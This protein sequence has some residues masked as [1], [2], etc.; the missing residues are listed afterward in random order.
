MMK[1]KNGFIKNLHYLCLI[2]VI[3]LGLM[4]II[5]T[6]G[7]GGSSTT[8]TIN[9]DTGDAGDEGEEESDTI[10]ITGDFSGGTHSKNLW[11]KKFF[12][13]LFRPAYALDPNQVAK[14][15]VFS[16]NNAITVS[17]VTN[18]A[19][20]IEVNKGFPVGM[21]FVG[22][23]DNYLGYL[24]LG[25]GID[26]IPLTEAPTDVRNIDLEKLLSSGPVVQPSHN[27]LGN[28][29]ALT[30][31]EQAAIAHCDDLFASIIRNPDVDGNGK[32][33]FLEESPMHYSLG[34]EYHIGGGSLAG[35]GTPIV[36]TPAKIS[37]YALVF[38]AVGDDRP[39]DVY[40]TGPPDSGLSNSPSMVIYPEEGY[41]TYIA[42]H[43]QSPAIPP[44]GEYKIHCG[45]KKLTF[46][47]PHPALVARN[48]VLVVPKVTLNENGTIYSINWRYCLGNGS[49]T[50][51]NPRR[52]M[53][54]G[55][56][57]HIFGEGRR[58][59]ES[60]YPH[61]LYVPSVAIPSTTTS[62]ILTCDHVYWDEVDNI[63]MGF[64]DVYGNNNFIHWYKSS[65]IET[66]WGSLPTG[67]VNDSQPPS[68]STYGLTTFQERDCIH[69]RTRGAEWD[70]V[71]A[72]TETT[73]RTGTYE[74]NV[75]VPPFN[76]VRTSNAIRTFLYSPQSTD[77]NNLREIGFEIGYG[78]GQQ[79]IDHEIPTG[80]LM[81]YM[82]VQKDESSG[83]PYSTNVLA[84][85]PD[86]WYTLR[87][88]LSTND[89]GQYV[90]SWKLKKEN[91]DAF[92]SVPYF[93]CEY[94][95]QDTSFYVEIGVESFNNLWIG[96]HQPALHKEAYFD[97]VSF[98]DSILYD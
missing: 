90:V 40:F 86:N 81:C 55:I 29:L 48:I 14:V 88:I 87:L 63:S 13:K 93:T 30:S 80:K 4:A 53:Q 67:W 10:T 79:R 64:S 68:L 6:G 3:V 47:I 34:V 8:P 92:H 19:F 1:A 44:E 59:E 7:G 58:C 74:W 75:Y 52:I 77:A 15:I 22:A 41:T 39:D 69:I 20:S 89:Q 38:Q 65:V 60:E 24:T 56:M 91:D 26:T 50:I 42:P 66:N 12:A 9:N 57:M 72:R 35:D 2:G 83:T 5:A 78:T 21:I 28:E 85:D 25:N 82:T 23:E 51:S 62:H 33:D 43:I 84:I 49:G 31:D 54:E 73:Y 70:R 61:I 94:G 98:N 32:I 11:L 36:D 97:R 76:E 45:S 96:D 18:G 46:T 17:P 27:P 95:P 71:R 37:G 16:M